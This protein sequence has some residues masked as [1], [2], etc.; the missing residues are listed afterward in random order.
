MRYRD[1][2]Q[3]E[4][5]DSIIQ[6]RDA[7]DKTRARE[8]V[9]SF[10]FSARMVEQLRELVIPNLRLDRA[11]D[12]K[13]IFVVGNYGT[14]KSHL[15]SVLSAVAEH[16]D[17]LVEVRNTDLQA[18]LAPVAGRFKVVRMELG[19]VTRR[20]R[21][22]VVEALERFFAQVGAPYTFPAVDAVSNNK[23]PLL[24][25][26][27]GFRTLFPDH[28]ILVVLDE[29]LDFLR[30]QDERALL[31]D[32]GFLRELGEVS[33]LA[34]FRFVAGVQESLFDSPSF[35]FVAG[36][37]RRVRERFDQVRI[38]REDIAYVV[39]ERL[40]RKTDP[41]LAL[42]TD[43]LRRFSSLYPAMAD[44]LQE[45]A[46]LF[47][48]HP[49]YIETLE[50][51]YIAE[52]REVL[53]TFTLA[54]NR[55][56]DQEVPTDQT[57]LIAYDHYWEMIKD[58]PSLRAQDGIAQV[59]A[60]SDV[61]AGRIENAYTRKNL[62][63]LARRIV[64]A[65]SVQRLTTSDI[66][67]P[68]GVTAE[69][70][71]DTLCLWTPMPEFQA[72]FLA[73]TV[74]VAL[75]EILRTVNGQYISYNQENG[76][77]YLD[78][79]KD[80]DFDANIK[81][82][83]DI[84]PVVDLNRYFFDA[85]VEMMGLQNTSVYVPNYRIWFYEL[86]WT[87]K[88][89]TRPG[90]FL[91]LA[92]NERSTA[93]PPR[94][95][96]LYFIPPYRAANAAP[97]TSDL[98]DEVL[99]SLTGLDESFEQIVRAY[100]GARALAGESPAH[101]QTYG[102]QA[103][104]HRRRLRR[105]LEENLTAKLRVTYRGV[106]RTAAEVMAEMRSTGSANLV[107]LLTNLASHLL[108][109]HFSDRYPDYPGFGRAPQPITE[110]NRAP[111]A[112][113]AIR[114]IAG[115]GR[116]NLGLG[117][118][119]GLQLLDDQGQTIRTDGS[120]YAQ[121]F[122][123]VLQARPDTQVVNYGEVLDQV[124][125][126]L[127]PL[128]KDARFGLEPEWVAVLLTA[129]VYD[130]Q[131]ELA[132][133]G[134]QPTLDASTVDRAATLALDDLANFRYYK[135]PRGLPL[136]QWQQI[137][138]GLGLQSAL[139]RE[140]N[141]RADAVR[142]LQAL[143]T[144]EVEE[145]AAWQGRVQ[146][147]L[148]LWN[149]SLFTDG[150][151]LQS[152]GGQVIAHSDLPATRLSSTDLLPALRGAKDFLEKLRPFN[153]PGKLR[154]LTLTTLQIQDG[155]A[156]RTAARRLAPLLDALDR[157]QPATAYLA[158]AEATLP[159]DPWTAAAATL[160]A[161]LLDALRQLA[162]GRADFTY[163][164]WRTRLDELKQR[165]IARYAELHQRARL[166]GPQEQRRGR[167]LAD[168]R[169]AQLRALGGIDIFR[170]QQEFATWAARAT[171]LT[172]CP[173]FHAGLLA[174]APV[175]PRCS[176]RPSG[177]DVDA[178]NQLATLAD[179]LDAIVH[180]WHQGLRAALESDTAQASIGA[181]TAAERRPLDAYLAAAEPSAE[182][183]T[184]LVDAANRALHGLRTVTVNPDAL[185]DALRHGGLPCTVAD[186]ERRFKHYVTRLLAGHDATNTRLTLE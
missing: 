176:Y 84:L 161:V 25:A 92:P 112:M 83:G 76:Q 151:V 104:A 154:N 136:A 135:R 96:Y 1:L 36:Q 13:G 173:E 106:T 171:A 119:H 60:K 41:Q 18:D 118:L 57:G 125:G 115:R 160:K 132:L 167:L 90:Y 72:Q 185:L 146:Q 172:P 124:A 55:V 108:T 48:I 10:V 175:C 164:A 139:L 28:G 142:D 44:R 7:D 183:P 123:E 137:F 174:D 67:A 162:H 156:H 163:S 79:K 105:W 82:R 178:A 149:R 114:M 52:Q 97:P 24:A 180:Q 61:L 64:A 128:F 27:A 94:D 15:M 69:E 95:F 147:G 148:S 5:L 91:C 26:V 51:V 165:Y 42:I 78:L 159:D 186:L 65:L 38:A 98:A 50:R 111:S 86:P 3:F 177:Q 179:Q 168:P 70:L 35:A 66:N 113:D 143:V 29:L 81:N 37:L 14:G 127:N 19:G 49:A 40:L 54:M 121:H 145:L 22:S 133:A 33:E 169:V 39:A 9:A 80:I 21:D 100:A 184:G 131:I 59:V 75:R 30:G 23:D 110:P 122:L 166:T 47:P 126:G 2:V 45:Y 31:L 155:L 17:L 11:A 157:L 138:Q 141:T 53:K 77:Y 20:L 16:P 74:S 129:L 6:V 88:K 85:L 120:P 103:D 56:L 12:A 130:G 181:M 43:H 109:P 134:T 116:T 32:L 89:V 140:E 117:V 71:R 158:T 152:Q 150:L 46:R 34:P 62:L 144:R 99:F 107:Q 93:Q 102:D 4:P 101:A 182:L 170:T 68:I 58:N 8:L 153:T 87:A 73:D 63:P